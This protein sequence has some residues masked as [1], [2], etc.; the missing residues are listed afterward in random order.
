M[1][2]TL[3]FAVSRP[4]TAKLLEDEKQLF[5]RTHGRSV[6][7]HEQ[8]RK[9][10]LDGVP[11][12]WML[13]WPGGH[14]VFVADAQ[15]THITDVDGNEYVDFCLGDTGAMAGHAPE[16]TA[17]ALA[18]QS[19][20]GNTMMLP[21]EDSIWVSAELARRFGLPLWQFGLSATDANRNA[22]RVARG[23]TGR[24]KILAMNRVYHG[25]VDDT[26]A[27]LDEQGHVVRR[28]PS[29]GAPVD[30]AVTTK[31]VEFNDLPALSR[32]LADGDV[33]CVLT[34]PVLSGHG[35]APPDPDFHPSLRALTREAGT[36]LIIDETHLI[37]AGPGGMTAQLGLEPDMITTG[38]VIAGGVPIGALGLS[39]QVAD[40]L[41]EKA[42]LPLTGVTGLGGT[43]AGNALSLAAAR[44]TLSEV[45]TEEAYDRM[46]GLGQRTVAGLTAEIERHGLPWHALSYGSRVEYSFRRVPPRN[47]SE[48]MASRDPLLEAF[49]HLFSLN[50]GVIVVPFHNLAMSSAA[51]SDADV[52][53]YVQVFGDAL[54]T[55][56]A[57]GAVSTTNGREAGNAAD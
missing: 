9:S 50:R 36:L 8:A 31:L 25:T 28:P 3:N 55:L 18:E 30:P 17:A 29:F 32:A 11:M 1:S 10:L 34:E 7:L 14:P 12:S 19:R 48:A 13:T 22:L 56:A 40:L 45:L 2:S 23:I 5:A 35:F 37:C 51:T 54:D 39:S 38:K 21:T 42:T 4:E 52:D 46:T 24:P 16:A 47:G 33:A 53:R 26:L 57:H 6:A 49:I 27:V 20:K 41:H 15:G 44:A 43:L